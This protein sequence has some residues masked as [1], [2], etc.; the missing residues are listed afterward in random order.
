MGV[1]VVVACISV[2]SIACT[3]DNRLRVVELC[4][5]PETSVYYNGVRE[6]KRITWIQRLRIM[7]IDK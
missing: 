1:V 3:G 7:H 2:C 6:K 4:T 5:A